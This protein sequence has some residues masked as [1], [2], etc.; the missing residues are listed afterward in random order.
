MLRYKIA[1]IDSGITES[2]SVNLTITDM[3]QLLFETTASKI[4]GLVNN[5]TFLPGDKLPSLRKL[6]R[7]W[8]VSIGTVLQAYML[9]EDKGIAE[10]KEK[11]GFFVTHQPGKS[12]ESPSPYKGAVV[13]RSVYNQKTLTKVAVAHPGKSFVSF[14]DAVPL[15]ESLPFP[16]I[17]RSVQVA[18]RDLKGTYI[19]YETTQGS[20]VLR[21][22]IAQRSFQWNGALK[23]DNIVIT[24]G[25]L[26]AIHLC[27][28]ATTSPGDAVVVETPCYYGILQCIENLQLRAIELPSHND[29]INL[30]ELKR[31]CKKFSVAACVL[32][33]TFN[34]PNGVTISNEK[35]KALAAF[36]Q[37]TK[38]PIMEDDIYGDLYFGSQR[39]HTI[40]TYDKDGWVLFCTSFSKTLAPGF[41]VGWCEAGRYSEQ[42]A[43][44]K[45]V[46][47]VAT[48]S[49]I[50]QTMIELLRSGSYDRHLRKLR[51]TLSRQVALTARA[52][53]E[54]FPVGTRISKPTGGYVLWIELN[55][56]VNT[57]KLQQLA[58]KNNI[59][60]APGFLFTGSGGFK[61]YIRISCNNPW[62]EK[63]DKALKK[64]GALCQEINR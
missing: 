1:D 60:F 50:Q 24:N 16:A 29:G 5:K 17:R 25:A 57:G 34:N 35:K 3:E 42:V 59:D 51:L 41:R 8:G 43:R 7:E 38:T 15:V 2:D 26:E 61:N 22:L 11:S 10:G 14:F 48:A 23:S 49:L 58:I 36:A 47:N 32:V 33:P 27:L 4:E 53:E 52:I 37:Q 18:S 44:L 20:S 62:S 63:I 64:L 12:V 55:K 21:Q 54:Y 46:T 31:V 9:L 6:S 40:K 39:P 13:A 28:R 45:A 19:S 56:K 30:K